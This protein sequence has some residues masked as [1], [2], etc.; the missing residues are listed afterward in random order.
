MHSQQSGTVA[1]GRIP[2]ESMKRFR[3]V[4]NNIF[5]CTLRACTCMN[6]K[7]YGIE[8]N[9]NTDRYHGGQGLPAIFEEYVLSSTS[10]V[11][12]SFYADSQP[13]NKISNGSTGRKTWYVHCLVGAK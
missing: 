6:M 1:D 4:I 2:T 8:L 3:A 12:T 7:K 13:S 9:G 5:L 10:C 11:H